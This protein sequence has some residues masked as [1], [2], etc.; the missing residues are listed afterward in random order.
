MERSRDTGQ[1]QPKQQIE[2]NEDY[3]ATNALD[4]SQ[5]QQL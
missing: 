2:L 3:I 4:P 1:Q 5:Q